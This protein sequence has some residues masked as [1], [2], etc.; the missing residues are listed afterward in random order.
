MDSDTFLPF[1]KF[2]I[3]DFAIKSFQSGKVIFSGDKKQILGV[4]KSRF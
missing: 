1:G 3:C 4:G 2:K